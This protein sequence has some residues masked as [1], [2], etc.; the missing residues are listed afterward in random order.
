MTGLAFSLLLAGGLMPWPM[1]AFADEA[2]VGVSPATDG[3][4]VVVDDAPMRSMSV[5][6]EG[7]GRIEDVEE[8][9]ADVGLEVTDVAE[10]ADGCTVVAAAAPSGESDE[11][12][13]AAASEL[14][15][16][17][18]AQPNYVYEMIGDVGS[19]AGEWALLSAKADSGLALY[20]ALKADDPY[21]QISS[22]YRSPNQYWLHNAAFSDAWNEVTADHAVTIAVLDTVVRAGHED[23]AAN[24]LTQYAW[25][26]FNETTIDFGK[27]DYSGEN[28]HGTHVAGVAAGVADNGLGIAGASY[29]AS[30]LPVQVMREVTNSAG[31]KVTQSSTRIL[32][33]AFSYLIDLKSRGVLP[34]LRVANMSLGSYKDSVNDC[35][36]REAISLARDKYGIATVCAGGNGD[37]AGNPCTDPLYPADFEDC[38][39]VTALTP[40]GTNALWSDYNQSKDISAPGVGIWSTFASGDGAYASAS[41]TSSASPMVAAAFALMF[42][43]VGSATVDDACTALYATATP[44]VDSEN[45]R[46]ETSGSHG[47]LDA[48]A[49]VAYL[50]AYFP[51]H[52]TDVASTSWY[53]NSV[54]FVA[55]RGIM[56]GYPTG[57]GQFGPEDEVSRAQMAA[58]LYKFMGEGAVA[59]AAPLSDV[60]Q[61]KWYSTSVN[62]A[63]ERAYMSGNGKTFGVDESLTR[64]QAATIIANIAG[65][66]V[67]AADSA[68]FQAFEDA[69]ITSGW[70][71][72][73]VIWAVDKGILNGA[74]LADG[75]RALLPKDSVTRAEL[76]A[77]MINAIDN[78]II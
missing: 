30:I 23:L 27:A 54:G 63:V 31:E 61:D 56:T 39:A 42:S 69:D 68:K 18:F 8:R 6:G 71:R 55:E 46:S 60:R 14:P 75:T 72:Q 49:A 78:G 64:E 41:G 24:V 19:D 45:D 77:I 50:K 58:T 21:A 29:N 17:V 70:A 5:D 65:A 38:V 22:P 33:R 73:S 43:E 52:F 10:V 66:D 20:A 1:M 2:D 37:A 48:E 26:A 11:E 28:A 40:Q 67:A 34:N 74:T 13:A 3:V 9:L 15:D 57:K 53:Y 44:I 32:V 12:A 35:L 36:L 25:D 76:A 62:W 7:V 59:P 51:W 4:L 16:V 47:A